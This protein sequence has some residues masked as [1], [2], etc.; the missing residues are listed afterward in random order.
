MSN[1]NEKRAICKM[2]FKNFPK[3]NGMGNIC[4]DECK[5]RSLR[6]PGRCKPSCDSLNFENVPV[7]FKNGTQHLKRFCKICRRGHDFAPGGQIGAKLIQQQK[8][9]IVTKQLEVRKEKY[10]DS[11][12]TS[13]AWLSVRYDAIIRS[14]RECELCGS[15]EKPLHVDH[16]K[17]R[18]K[19]PELELS[20]SNLQILCAQCNLGK[21]NKTE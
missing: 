10:K 20:I 1:N 11:F 19:F 17:P 21:S 2:C 5:E 4:S 14:T 13:R 6:L 16:I 8:S 7:I 9:I 3:K 18:S 15:K 12:Y